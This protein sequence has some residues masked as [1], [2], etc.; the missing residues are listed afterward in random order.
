MVRPQVIV[1]P[2][3]VVRPQVVIHQQAPVQP[4]APV[5]AQ[6]PIQSRVPVQAQVPVQQRPYV[7]RPLIRQGAVCIPASRHGVVEDMMSEDLPFPQ[8][9]TNEDRPKANDKGAEEYDWLH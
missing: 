5:Q 3:V 1:C 7:R 2:Q 6:V 8:T 4:Q 9:E